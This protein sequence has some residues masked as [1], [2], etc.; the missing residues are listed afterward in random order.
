MSVLLSEE[1]LIFKKKAIA[2]KTVSA[3]WLSD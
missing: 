2:K 3:K 1:Y